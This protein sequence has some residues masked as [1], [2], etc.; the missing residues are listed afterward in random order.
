M[1]GHATHGQHYEILPRGGQEA[2]AR[3]L[4]IICSQSHPLHH[5]ATKR[6]LIYSQEK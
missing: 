2:L 3:T 5:N 1:L 6:H 4:F